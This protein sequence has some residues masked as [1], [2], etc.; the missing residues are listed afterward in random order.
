MKSK[1]V[2]IL[3]NEQGCY[4]WCTFRYKRNCWATKQVQ[5]CSNGDPCN[6]PRFVVR[7]FN[8]HTCDTTT[9]GCEPEAAANPAVLPGLP[10]T[11][12]SLGLS[13][14]GGD[15]DDELP[16]S[17]AGGSGT[18]SSAV[19]FNVASGGASCAGASG[20][21]AMPKTEAGT[22]TAGEHSP[23]SAGPPAGEAASYATVASPPSSSSS[24]TGIKG[25]EPLATIQEMP[26]VV[27]TGLPNGNRVEGF[28]NNYRKGEEM[29]IVC[30]CHGSFHTP[31]GFVEHAGG[32]NVTNPLRHIALSLTPKTSKNQ[33]DVTIK[34]SKAVQ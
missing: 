25:E 30:I 26:R 24:L 27:T 4:Y 6:P 16:Q 7:Y 31:A 9:A 8:D 20:D 5:Q 14:L 21:A 10:G 1:P 22:T 32:G 18:T 11:W 34:D 3:P 15:G 23:S 29:R 2:K 12:L 13:S 17:P 28:L 19:T 33:A